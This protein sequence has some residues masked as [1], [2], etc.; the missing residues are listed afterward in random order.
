MSLPRVQASAAPAPARVVRVLARAP[1]DPNNNQAPAQAAQ[2]V[3]PRVR[4]EDIGRQGPRP[5]PAPVQ[6]D[7]NNPP[8]QPQQPS[9]S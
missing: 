9:T 1:V 6:V 5:V 8:P 2:P 3:R 4:L 7:I